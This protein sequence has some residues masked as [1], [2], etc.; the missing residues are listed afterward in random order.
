[1]ITLLRGL[2]FDY[3]LDTNFAAD[4]TI[5]EVPRSLLRWASCA[6]HWARIVYSG[7]TRAAGAR[8]EGR[9][10]PDVY[11]VLPRLGQFR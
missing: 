3:V 7:R 6:P 4:L 1:M 11:V 10:I 8:E 2:G 5:M 9:A